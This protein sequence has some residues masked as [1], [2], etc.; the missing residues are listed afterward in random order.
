MQCMVSL[1][2]TGQCEER[3]RANQEG[4]WED[5]QHGI[6][7]ASTDSGKQNRTESDHLYESMIWDNL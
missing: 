4:E 6:F 1:W 5:T 7:P 2:G 3:W